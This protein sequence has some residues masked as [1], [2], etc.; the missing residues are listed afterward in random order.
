MLV[1]V[2]ALNRGT[3][4]SIHLFSLLTLAK[5]KNKPPPPK[6]K[7]KCQIAGL[8]SLQQ[9]KQKLS[10][11]KTVV[12]DPNTIIW[13]LCLLRVFLRITGWFLAPLTSGPTFPLIFL[14]LLTPFR[15][16]FCCPS[17]L[18]PN[19]A[20]GFSFSNSIPASSNWYL[21][22]G[23]RN[24]TAKNN[25]WSLKTWEVFSFSSLKNETTF[26]NQWYILYGW[27]SL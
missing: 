9:L 20:L 12:N 13:V 21:L 6:E 19:P 25:C 16:P 1:L 3:H 18:F 26:Q 17:H 8:F 22:W 11:W 2:V 7:E 24:A 14:L 10:V 23:I 15:S 5:G 4:F 27:T